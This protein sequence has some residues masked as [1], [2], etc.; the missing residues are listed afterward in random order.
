MFS[1]K[2]SIFSGCHG[3]SLYKFKDAFR[4]HSNISDGTFCENGKQLKAVNYVKKKKQI[5]LSMFD[6]VVNTP[7]QA[8]L[9]FCGIQTVNGNILIRQNSISINPT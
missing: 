5:P 2:S 8:L 1:N 7:L 4:I 3:I 9:Y 6:W